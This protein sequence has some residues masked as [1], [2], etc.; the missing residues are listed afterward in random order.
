MSG[1]GCVGDGSRWVRDSGK[2]EGGV[3]NVWWLVRVKS[4]I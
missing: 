1:G 3:M 4:N 2:W